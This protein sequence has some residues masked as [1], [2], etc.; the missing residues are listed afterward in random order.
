[1]RRT[2]GQGNQGVAGHRSVYDK[3]WKV[4][5]RHDKQVSYSVTGIKFV[6]CLFKNNWEK[7]DMT[8]QLAMNNLNTTPVTALEFPPLHERNFSKAEE[9]I[10]SFFPFKV[11]NTKNAEEKIDS[12]YINFRIVLIVKGLNWF[13]NVRNVGLL[14]YSGNGFKIQAKMK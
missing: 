3:T 11:V 1:M 7:T 5:W 4:D 9:D 8:R 10:N 13:K 14:G 12:S 2:R 6:T